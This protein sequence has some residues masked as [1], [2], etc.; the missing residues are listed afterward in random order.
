MMAV[1][2]CTI[3]ID[4]VDNLQTCFRVLCSSLCNILEEFEKDRC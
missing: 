1:M 2:N 4:V 3:F